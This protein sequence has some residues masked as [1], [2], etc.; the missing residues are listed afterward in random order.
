MRNRVCTLA[1]L[2]LDGKEEKDFFFCVVETVRSFML[3]L[4]LSGK[5]RI[6]SSLTYR[7]PTRKVSSC[8]LLLPSNSS[9]EQVFSSIFEVSGML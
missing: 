3:L 1:F 5:A 6:C 8:S 4:M 7:N 9:V 2:D